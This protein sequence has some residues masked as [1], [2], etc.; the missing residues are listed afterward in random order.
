MRAGVAWSAGAARITLGTVFLYA[1][2]AKLT[3]FEVL[4]IGPA[5]GPRVFAYVIQRNGL[6]PADWSMPVAIAVIAA[7]MLLGLWLLSHRRGVSAGLCAVGL[8][9]VFSMY[10][11]VAIMHQGTAPCNCFGTLHPV[12]VQWA[13]GRNLGLMVVALVV[14]VGSWHESP[15]SGSRGEGVRR[16]D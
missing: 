8:L 5:S 14:M 13:I 15:G 7:E 12:G 2:L 3:Q 1:A 4:P 6:I 16:S 11:V 9:A 10:L